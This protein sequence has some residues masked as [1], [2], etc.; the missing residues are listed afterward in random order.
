MLKK[1]YSHAVAD[2][3]VSQPRTIGNIFRQ[4][5][6]SPV[7]HKYRSLLCN[8]IILLMPGYVICIMYLCSYVY[9]KL[10]KPVSGKLS[11]D[12]Y[13]IKFEKV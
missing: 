11:L 4:Q 6:R 8:F 9:T 12:V 7:S 1:A 2:K 3:Q 5:R 13:K 10:L